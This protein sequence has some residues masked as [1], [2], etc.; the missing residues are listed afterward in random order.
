MY[1]ITVIK[2]YEKTCIKFS[3]MMAKRI[4]F[5][6]HLLKDNPDENSPKQCYQTILTHFNK[7][8]FIYYGLLRLF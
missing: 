5:Y 6:R 7:F 1:S 2:R 4:I 8:S 3:K